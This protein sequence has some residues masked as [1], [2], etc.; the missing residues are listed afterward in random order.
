MSGGV[1]LEACE[2]VQSLPCWERAWFLSFGT[3]CGEDCLRRFAQ[4]RATL[5]RLLR[6]SDDFERSFIADSISLHFSYLPIQV[7]AIF[8]FACHARLSAGVKPPVWSVLIPFTVLLPLRF[9]VVKLSGYWPRLP[10]MEVTVLFALLETVMFWSPREFWCF[11]G[12]A[13]CQEKARAAQ[14][15]GLE[16]MIYGFQLTTWYNIIFLLTF[17]YAVLS[18]TLCVA[19]GAV[20]GFWINAEV[21]GAF[22]HLLVGTQAVTVSIALVVKV[23][24]ELL[25]RSQLETLQKKSQ[26]LTQ[27]KVL[28]CQAE[29]AKEKVEE[30]LHQ[31]RGTEKALGDLNGEQAEW[32]SKPQRPEAP[33][34]HSAPAAL[35]CFLPP[36]QALGQ[37]P[38]NCLRL[39]SLVFV[40]GST[41]PVKV[42]E[43]KANQSVLCYD[44]LSKCMKYTEV[45]NTQVLNGPAAWVCVA[46]ADG[47]SLEMTSDHPVQRSAVAG[48]RS[49]DTV[50]AGDLK[51]GADAATVLRMV[52]VPVVSVT[53]CQEQVAPSEDNRVA[54]TLRQPERHSVFV[55]GKGDTVSATMAVG[56]ANAAVARARQQLQVKHTFFCLEEDEDYFVPFRRSL[57]APPELQPCRLE[58]EDQESL[59]SPRTASTSDWTSERSRSSNGSRHVSI[60]TGLQPTDS[61]TCDSGLAALSQLVSVR[62]GGLKS[63]GSFN[64]PT[65]KPCAHQARF[66][67][68]GG[69][70][71]LKGELC[72]RCHEEHQRNATMQ[73]R[74][75]AQRRGRAKRNEAMREASQSSVPSP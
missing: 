69:R 56:S 40:E 7:M 64:H 22:G 38:G 15:G 25:Q 23:H 34:L 17:R 54:L 50:C 52:P 21:M 68:I 35:P 4:K 27:E 20:F 46:L 58:A 70:P 66:L 53:P 61:L 74:S 48:S 65:C 9:L 51:P 26:E 59:P 11:G 33:S 63:A 12:G 31:G 30:H 39:D 10:L 13:Q 37:G 60:L 71:C 62:Q 29:F 45:A 73:R 49:G 8:L 5:Q 6:R 16:A 32:C 1:D 57:S 18:G 14:A 24:L 42:Q 19:A 44:N 75:G 55:A 2:P 43:V 36:G 3:R 28:R 41:L 47:T 72:T 67:S